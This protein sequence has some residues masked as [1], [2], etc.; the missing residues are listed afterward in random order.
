MNTIE[1]LQNGLPVTIPLW[2]RDT[3]LS[4]E[5]HPD[6]PSLTVYLAS[7]EF[8]TGQMVVICP[9]GGYGGLSVPKEGHRVARFLS[10]NG[11]SAAVLEYRIAPYQHPVPLIDAHRAIRMLR[12]NADDWDYR[13]D[14]I[15]ILGFSAGGHLA[16]CA[17]TMLPKE[18]GLIG[19]EIDAESSRPDFAALIY[20]VIS[21][22]KDYAHLGSRNNL[23]G[24]K[25]DRAL[26]REM[27]LENAV[28]K[29]TPPIPLIHTNED[30][31]VP[32]ENSV[33]LYKA[34]RAHKVS[35]ALHIYER[36]GHGIGLG[37]DYTYPWGATMLNW[38]KN[39]IEAPK[40]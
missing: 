4:G 23:L 12:H 3:P 29:R 27:S 40:A 30:E 21:F 2:I 11:I 18:K 24:D 38:L 15:G 36:H 16:G 9:G 34:L 17:A 25:H 1:T 32:L 20:P 19:D 28:T 35:A 31:P 22:T 26:A 10:S 13:A 7:N 39:R 6:R 33:L 14:Q 5:G 37:Y 8:Q